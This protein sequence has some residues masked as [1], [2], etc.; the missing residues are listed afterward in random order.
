MPCPE[1]PVP[2]APS[3]GPVS[4]HTTT[5][6]L[7][8]PATSQPAFTRSIVQL[9]SPRPSPSYELPFVADDD[10]SQVTEVFPAFESEAKEMHIRDGNQWRE[11]HALAAGKA[12]TP[13]LQEHQ[14]AP[15][16]LGMATE[17]RCVFGADSCFNKDFRVVVFSTLCR[18]PLPDNPRI[19][20]SRKEHSAHQ[21][22][23]GLWAIRLI[24]VEV[25]NN[26]ASPA[27]ELG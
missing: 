11:G 18:F 6:G 10:N 22:G 21:R 23:Q 19:F 2:S 4:L 1:T 14:N 5:L 15:L 7:V 8:G 27:G 16:S 3:T 12:T 9:A 17:V 26:S 25:A 24:G 13:V 20:R